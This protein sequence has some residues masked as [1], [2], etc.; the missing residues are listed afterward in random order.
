MSKTEP[1]VSESKQPNPSC[2]VC[3]G[4]GIVV[5]GV[6]HKACECTKAE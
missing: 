1:K 2:G 3:V 4:T 6:G 5:S